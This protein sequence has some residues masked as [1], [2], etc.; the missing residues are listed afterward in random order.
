MKACFP[1]V[2]DCSES[3]VAFG[4]DLLFNQPHTLS[5]HSTCGLTIVKAS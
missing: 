1:K 2:Y 4:V 5:H 3:D